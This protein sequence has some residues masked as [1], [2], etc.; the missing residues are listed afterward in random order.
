MQEK[1]Y[2]CLRGRMEGYSSVSSGLEP[3][4]KADD[5]HCPAECEARDSDREIEEHHYV[6][7]RRIR[8]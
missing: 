8:R 2:T 1:K 4:F 7:P 3:A 6:W 5:Q